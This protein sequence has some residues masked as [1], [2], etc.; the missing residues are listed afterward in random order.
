MEEEEF[1]R[2]EQ[3]LG[4]ISHKISKNDVSPNLSVT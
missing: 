4:Q 3:G 1:I 2:P